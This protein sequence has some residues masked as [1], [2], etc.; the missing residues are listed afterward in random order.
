VKASDQV[1]S[2]TLL[3]FVAIAP[4]FDLCR[5]ICRLSAHEEL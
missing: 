2:Q 1:L 5:D 4:C 3:T